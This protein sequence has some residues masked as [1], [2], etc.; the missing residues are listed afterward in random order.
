MSQPMFTEEFQHLAC[1]PRH[2]SGA[3]SSIRHCRANLTHARHLVVSFHAE[4]TYWTKVYCGA[5]IEFRADQEPEIV[6][7]TLQKD[8]KCLDR[9]AVCLQAPAGQLIILHVVHST[10]GCFKLIVRPF[11][12]K[13]RIHQNVSVTFV[14]ETKFTKR[15]VRQR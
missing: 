9:N 14:S 5:G 11:D 6:Y 4:R 3:S 13:S 1:R 8:V 15:F 2:R 12:L 7:G 10:F